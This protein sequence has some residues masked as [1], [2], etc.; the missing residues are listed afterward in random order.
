MAEGVLAGRYQFLHRLGRGAMGEVWL[1]EDLLLN[2]KVAVKRLPVQG[3][4]DTDLERMMREARTAAR[5]NHPNVVAVYDVVLDEGR[6][7]VVIEYVPGS[8]LDDLLA[9][10]GGLEPGRVAAIGAAIADALAEA[11]AN[12]I[13]H[14]DVKPA[15]ILISDKGVPKLADFGI[16]RAAADP[17]LTATGLL[18]GTPAYVAPELALGGTADARSDVWSLGMTL[19]AALEGRPAFAPTGTEQPIVVLHRIVTQP[20]PHPTLGGPVS[21]AVLRLLTTDADARP[22]AV[23]A[24]ELFRDPSVLSAVRTQEVAPPPTGGPPA[25]P[26]TFSSP[27]SS[28]PPLGAPPPAWAATPHP[29]QP[30]PP[31]PLPPQPLP[32]QARAPAQPPPAWGTP[33][34]QQVPAR[35]AETSGG[36]PWQPGGPPPDGRR[37]GRRVALIAAALVILAGG[38]TAVALVAANGGDGSPRA[39]LS[40]STS[41]SP[42]APASSSSARSASGPVSSPALVDY[43]SG[44][45]IVCKMAP[46]WTKE[47]SSTD[48]ITFWDAPGDHD[49]TGTYLRMGLY[50]TTEANL[51]SAFG[52][53]RYYLTHSKSPYTDAVLS[54]P[55][56][57]TYQ[58]HPAV[59]WDITGTDRTTG[60]RRRAV[61]RIWEID[62]VTRLAQLNTPA[63]VWD[64][65]R[66]LFDDIMQTCR[67]QP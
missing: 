43:T 64:R 21:A 65:D 15:N 60:V 9:E 22:T 26:P 67:V 61:A 52:H 33:P 42:S 63:T 41:R 10:Q 27:A 30:L 38:G 36:N 18:I 56:Y 31:Q 35:P 66:H 34:P 47:A 58:G 13:V 32:P 7:H 62:G 5:L 6:P 48:T 17:N 2:R 19:F 59:D 55:R 53:A 37:G 12:G 50:S 54:T 44:A 40:S 51:Q 28:T 29:P 24:A 1:A 57:G 46:G 39:I 20:V 3:G 45:G 11:H 25:T 14:R 16:A 49:Q 8:S 4:G 23:E